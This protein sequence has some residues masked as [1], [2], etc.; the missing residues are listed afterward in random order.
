M[1]LFVPGHLPRL[2]VRI[3]EVES[4]T[5]LES[6]VVRIPILNEFS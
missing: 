4:Q 5:S 3:N 6:F 1:R 2:L